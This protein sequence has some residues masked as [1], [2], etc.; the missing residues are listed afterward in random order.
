M[1]LSEHRHNVDEDDQPDHRCP[2][3]NESLQPPRTPAGPLVQCGKRQAGVQRMGS[4]L[5]N[6][7]RSDPRLPPT[8]RQHGVYGGVSRRACG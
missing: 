4:P 6:R 3:E 8:R 2:D 1:L 5:L 7:W